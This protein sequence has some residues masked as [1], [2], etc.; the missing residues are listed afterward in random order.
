MDKN[1]LKIKI[2]KLINHYKAGNFIHVIKEGQIVIKKIPNNI[3]LTNLIAMSHQAIGN[4]KLAISGYYH[5]IGLDNQNKE[6]YNNLGTVLKSANDLDESN[7]PRN[8]PTL[9]FAKT[10][11]IIKHKV[12]CKCNQN[13][14]HV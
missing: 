3:F 5:I 8:N 10:Q 7:Y 1:I 12:R 4:F 14:N 6:A 9:N 13:Q 2:E 11:S